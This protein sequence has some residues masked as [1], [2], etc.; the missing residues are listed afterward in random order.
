MGVASYSNR[1]REAPK[2]AM[3]V[4]RSYAILRRIFPFIERVFADGG[5]AGRSSQTPR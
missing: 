4:D 1:S 5:Y 3:A 2:I